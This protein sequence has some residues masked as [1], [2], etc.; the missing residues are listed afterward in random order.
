MEYTSI[1]IAALSTIGTLI[2]FKKL[3]HTKK[4][5]KNY[6][7]DLDNLKQALQEGE[8]PEDHAPELMMTVKLRDPIA[9]AKQESS[10]AKIAAGTAPHIVIRKCYEQVV[11]ETI[12]QMKGRNIEVDIT[13]VAV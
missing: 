4:E 7:N 13:L 5:L 2:L 8:H 9:A 1:A 10:L 12:D 3:Q 11:R 6:E